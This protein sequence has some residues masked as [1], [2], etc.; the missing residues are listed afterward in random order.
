M[1]R[2]FAALMLIA[3]TLLIAACGTIAT[4]VWEQPEPSPTRIAPT[5]PDVP[6]TAIAAAVN[7]ATPVRPTATTEA[8]TATFTP[9]PPTSMPTEM[10]APAVV[11]TEDPIGVLVSISDPVHGQQLFTTFFDQAGYMCATCHRVDSEDRLIGPGLLNIGMR[12]GA[13]GHAT[14]GDGSESPERYI[15]TSITNSQAFVVEGYPENLM[16]QMYSQILSEQ[17][18]YD[19]IAYLMTLQ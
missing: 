17:D 2:K 15:Y 10:V 1:I 12:A 8:A 7:S 11:G 6:P 19:L 16:P 9:E 3:L 13:G 14:H 5:A 18:I 4:P